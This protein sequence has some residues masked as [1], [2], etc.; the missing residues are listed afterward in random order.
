[1]TLHLHKAKKLQLKS[2]EMILTGKGS[3]NAVDVLFLLSP[4]PKHIHDAV[5]NALRVIGNG[6]FLGQGH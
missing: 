2:D 4:T 3:Q 6:C 5:R 1:M